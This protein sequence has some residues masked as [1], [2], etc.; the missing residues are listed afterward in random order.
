[1]IYASKRDHFEDVNRGR[2]RAQNPEMGLK[3][4]L[5]HGGRDTHISICQ[6]RLYSPVAKWVLQNTGEGEMTRLPE[7]HE[8]PDSLTERSQWVC[9][10]ED[11]RDGNSTKVPVNPYTGGFA[12]TTDSETWSDFETAR[13]HAIESGIGLGFVFTEDDSLVGIDLDKCRVPTTGTASDWAATIIDRLDSYTEVSPSGT[14]FH[15]IVEGALPAGR[16]RRDTVEM[17]AHSRYFT[18]TG[19]HVEETPRE[20]RERTDALT[21]IHRE[22]VLEEAEGDKEH[23]SATTTPRVDL[24]D[25][26]LLERARAAQNGSKFERLWKGNTRGYDSHSEADM[27]LCAI[28]AFWSGGDSRQVD[29]LFRS[30]SLYRKKWDE[31]H[32]ADGSTYGEKTVERAIEG[33]TEFYTPG[34]AV[35]ADVSPF[36][37]E[38]DPVSARLTPVEGGQL[39]TKGSKDWHEI[40]EEMSQSLSELE[41]ENDDLRIALEE[42]RAARRVLEA[43]LKERDGPRS[44][45][46]RLLKPRSQTHRRDDSTADR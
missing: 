13:E 25:E 42:E 7:R 45:W 24:D 31:V 20:I 23:H 43:Q 33:T 28:L 16:N 14:G 46:Q 3:L 29:R 22:Y 11:E 30:S 15:V 4:L 1:M 32:F 37:R 26:T 17:Y 39:A 44:L 8:L 5:N 12:S 2:T 21:E 40:V 34:G 41:R 35:E 38:P 27:A 36:D 10:R 9:W 19:E 6:R 18:V